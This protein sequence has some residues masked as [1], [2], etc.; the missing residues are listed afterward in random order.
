MDTTGSV[1]KVA[2]AA[3]AGAIA[4]TAFGTF[5]GDQQEDQADG[6][7]LLAAFLVVVTLLV[8]GLVVR[9]STQTHT[10]ANS[11]ALS[12]LITSI[13]GVLT[14]AAF[15]SGLPVIFGAAGALLGLEGRQ[16]ALQGAGRA[17]M[18]QAALI[19][20]LLSIVAT[21]ALFVGDQLR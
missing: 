18:A 7:W 20:G 4:L 14:V 6:Y 8:F 12:G 9:Q 5:V 19:L 3:L 11:P 21:L 16:R 13:S 2:A 17:G 15:W 1:S 10:E